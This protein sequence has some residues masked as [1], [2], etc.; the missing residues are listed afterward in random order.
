MCTSLLSK[1]SMNSS[2]DISDFILAAIS[3][4][5]LILYEFDIYFKIIL[6]LASIYSVLSILRPDRVADIRKCNDVVECLHGYFTLLFPAIAW[7][8]L[9]IPV[10]T[11]NDLVENELL[12]TILSIYM[13]VVIIDQCAKKDLNDL[14]VGIN[15]LSLV[16]VAV[17][18]RSLNPIY[19]AILF[20]IAHFSTFYLKDN[21]ATDTSEDVYSYFLAAFI[22]F[23]MMWLHNKEGC[24]KSNAY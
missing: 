20:I 17:I 2:L 10:W 7:P 1:F 21:A 13:F 23:S 3:I 22:Y 8:C 19:E 4:G 18:N 11:G 9:I 15:S 24:W 14:L 6:T 12:Y 16:A 5:S